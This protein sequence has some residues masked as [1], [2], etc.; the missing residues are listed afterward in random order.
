MFIYI[1]ISDYDL[2]VG[3]H[4]NACKWIIEGGGSPPL[5]LLF[6]LSLSCSHSLFSLHHLLYQTI[7]ALFFSF[8]FFLNPFCYMMYS[9]VIANDGACLF[10]G[11][12]P[13]ST[14]VDAFL[15]FISC[16]THFLVK[17]CSDSVCFLF[18]PFPVFRI[19]LRSF[20]FFPF[21]HANPLQDFLGQTFCT[22]GEIVGSP[23]SRLEK[24]LG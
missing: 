24:P 6:S 20:F 2:W 22:L 23:A 15:D 12:P 4:I 5:L 16:T 19:C 7:S 8:S 11:S 18:T 9:F 21:S 10:P 14:Y 1:F 3:I 17:R 13:N